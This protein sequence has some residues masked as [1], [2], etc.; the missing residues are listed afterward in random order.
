MTHKFAIT[1]LIIILILTFPLN[2]QESPKVGLVLSGGGARGFAHIGVLKMLDSL[3][4]R[5]DYIAGTSMGGI[6]G[7]LYAI[8][9]SGEELETIVRHT[10]WVEIF[11]DKPRRS[12]Q[13]YYQKKECGRYQLN[14]GIVDFKPV[15]P[16]GLIIGQKLYLLFADLIFPF[17]KIENF[18]NLPI[19]FRCVAVNLQSGREFVIKS[20]SLD[21][22]MRTTM[23]IPS[24]FSP[25]EWGDSVYIDGGI[26]NNLPVDVVKEMG[27][28]IVIAVDV[29]G[30]QKNPAPDKSI[31]DVFNSTISILGM[32]RW[33]KNVANSDIYIQPDLNEFTMTDFIDDKIEKIITRGDES[34]EQFKNKLTALR[35]LNHL[36]CFHNVRDLKA[37]AGQYTVR[38]IRITGPT[39]MDYE[40]I[41]GRVCIEKGE[42]FD[43]DKFKQCIDRLRNS[44]F[45]KE[46]SYE[47]IPLS[48][49]GIRIDVRVWQRP[50][51]V[52]SS[53]SIT[54]NKRHSY[55]FI[56]RLLGLKPG[57][58][59]NTEDLH[60]RIMSLYSYGYFEKITYKLEQV[61]EKKVHLKLDIKE[62]PVRILRFGMR[63]DNYHKFVGIISSQLTDIPFSGM[64]VVNEVQF[65]GLWNYNLLV[66][67]PS[68]TIDPFIRLNYKDIPL[69][70]YNSDG[71]ISANYKN[72]SAGASVGIGMFF[73]GSIRGEVSYNIEEVDTKP[74]ITSLDPEEF[75]DYKAGLRLI[76]A[77][78]D[79]DYLDDIYMPRKG[80]QVY[81]EFEGSYKK[82]Y[83]D[84]SYQRFLIYGDFYLSKGRSTGR[85][86]LFSGRGSKDLPLY[87]F[88]NQGKPYAFT[89]MR[90][91]QLFAKQ[92]ELVRMEYRYQVHRFLYIRAIGNA[93]FD[94][95]DT[96]NQKGS[97]KSVFGYGFGFT[98]AYPIGSLE[99][100]LSRGDRNFSSPREVQTCAYLS[101]G[102]KF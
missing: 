13:P 44:G 6:L 87:K 66:H 8:G 96:G 18:D 81:S 70:L 25:V 98:F 21:K 88:F 35:D 46:V 97:G 60:R 56:Y 15:L 83:S 75:P 17:N 32:E 52:I 42:K 100:V 47:L 16:S 74:T 77:S 62:K 28:D 37:Q 1:F 14:F 5:I 55:G 19:P 80:F 34:A 22:A 31:F 49:E 68:R 30:Q 33:R 61:D 91:D 65:A 10:D 51:P 86:Y 58:K 11:S 82:L 93:A 94:I 76:K 92:M 72:R 29:M 64:R 27:A 40:K 79:L 23:A 36:E 69:R 78:L 24:I 99:F 63:F 57:E 45:F 39:T 102:A 71:L 84:L 53:I 73:S 38:E 4:I 20:G 2:A 9:Y 43:P 54:G 7:A 90:W 12:I 59:L 3:N 50:E 89:G 26:S 85:L 95:R 101:I 48:D 67:Y 41:R